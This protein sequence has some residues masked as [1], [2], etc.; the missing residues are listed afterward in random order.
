M[1]IRKS[2]VTTLC[3]GLM[4]ASAQAAPLTNF[5]TYNESIDLG[6]WKT[7]ATVSSVDYSGKY[8]FD[9]SWTA[10][11]GGRWGLQ[12]RHFNMNAKDTYEG[13]TNEFNAIYSLG[14]DSRVA[15]FAG[16]NRVSNTF[17]GASE[18][19]SI[20]QGGVQATA[21]LGHVVDGYVIAGVGAH[22][23]AQA[24]VGLS[25]KLSSDWQANLGYR[26]FKINDVLTPEKDVKVKGVTFGLTYF[27]DKK[28]AADPA[29]QQP[30]VEPK[31]QAE[32]QKPIE[33]QAQTEQ[34]PV[35][36]QKP[37]EE[38]K[39]AQEQKPAE[40]IVLKGVN[41]DLNS[42]RLQPQSYPV[43]DQVVTIAKEHPDWNYLLIGHTDSWGDDAVNM[44]LSWRRVKAV[45]TYLVN[46]GVAADKISL[47][48]KGS[49]EPIAS[50]DT[51]AGRAENRRVELLI[52]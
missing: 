46:H 35:I 24:E 31:P 26:W 19:K 7:N 33:Q 3:V 14:K 12:Y 1:S 30:I 37:A 21:P 2:L 16:V 28:K 20:F 51:A 27:F 41:F 40:K 10:G 43:L 18:K 11:I 13:N 38:Q 39:P 17:G 45:K 6:V 44:D 4:A 22:S 52:K 8:R 34:K 9:G 50:N 48:A 5:D 29:A 23:L 32:Q 15:L 42:D 49:H 47:E 25:A 36:V